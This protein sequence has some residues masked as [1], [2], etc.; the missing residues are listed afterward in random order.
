[1][2]KKSKKRK[3]AREGAAAS[4][5]SSVVVAVAVGGEHTAFLASDGCVLECGRAGGRVGSNA[6]PRKET[7]SLLPLLSMKS[8]NISLAHEL[9]SVCSVEALL[10]R[11]ECQQGDRFRDGHSFFAE[12]FISS[13]R[14]PP[15]SIGQQH[16]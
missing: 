9:M 4:S 8:A 7:F 3:R 1:M 6:T 12:P 15:E 11:S 14:M 13:R 16:V 2:G 5:S 10:T